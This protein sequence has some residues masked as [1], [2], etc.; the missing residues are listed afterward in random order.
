M[1]IREKDVYVEDLEF[2][3]SGFAYVLIEKESFFVIKKEGPLFRLYIDHPDRRIGIGFHNSDET[4][5]IL[6]S[7][8]EQREN[9]K[10]REN[11]KKS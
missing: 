7:I 5:K 6:R 1:K 11:R 8:K 9:K 10:E 3:E 2:S 4:N